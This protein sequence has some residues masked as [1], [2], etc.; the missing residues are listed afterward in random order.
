MNRSAFSPARC[1]RAFLRVL[2][3]GILCALFG[4][5]CS[6]ALSATVRPFADGDRVC[7]LG[8]SITKGGSYH[9]LLELFYSLRFPGSAIEFFNCGV[10]GDRAKSILAASGYRIE[11]DVLARQP[12]VITVMLGMNDVE[13]SLY[14]PASWEREESARA[15][16]LETYRT[17]VKMLVQ[18]LQK[19]GAHVILLSPTIYEESS[20]VDKTEVFPGIN[21]ALASCA[22]ILAQ[23]SDEL[24]T[25]FVDVH[26]LMHSLNQTQQV[27]N[28]SFSITGNGQSWND[29]VHPGPTGHFV[30]AHA[31]LSAQGML[32]N[33]PELPL[34]GQR[35]PG[36]SASDIPAQ[37][38]ALAEEGRRLGEDLRETATFRYAMAKEGLDPSDSALAHWLKEKRTAIERVGKPAPWIDRTLAVL[39]KEKELEQRRRSISVEIRGKAASL[40]VRQTRDEK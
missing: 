19:S 40:A 27:K 6:G 23:V 16:A 7:F 29:R 33:A 9:Q 8:D 32:P 20:Y 11:T 31:L 12:T 35:V 21:A 26:S 37:L 14:A 4:F 2:L 39:E 22:R 5:C 15:A 1:P 17:S 34:P 10:G 38:L 24:H 25:D 36:F 13:R 18:V 28:P 3:R 30:I